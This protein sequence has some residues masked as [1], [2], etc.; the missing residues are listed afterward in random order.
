MAISSVSTCFRSV[1]L[2]TVEKPMT[3]KEGLQRR[4]MSMTPG[5]KKIVEAV[6]HKATKIVFPCKIRF[7]Y[8]GRHEVIKKSRMV[9]PFIGAMKQFNTNDLQAL[10]PSG[11]V[12]MSSTIILRKKVR[13][14]ERKNTLLA[15]YRGRSNWAGHMPFNMNTEE[16]ATLWHFPITGQVK[17][18]QLQKTESK[19]SE[20][21][22]NLP[23]A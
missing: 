13:N 3:D 20:P 11:K 8:A 17:S 10:K 14:T 12:G 5:E 16:L 21:P 22:I 2:Y 4:M 18:P 23:Y 1:G 7:I 9:N 15:A 6:E 19:R